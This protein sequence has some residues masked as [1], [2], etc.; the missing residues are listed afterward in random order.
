MVECTGFENR[1]TVK[2]L[3]GSNPSLSAFARRSFMRRRD[4]D[5]YYGV[6]FASLVCEQGYGGQSPQ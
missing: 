6:Y 5:V 4:S 3:E 2:G 1:Q